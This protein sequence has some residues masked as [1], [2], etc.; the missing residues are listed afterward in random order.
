VL[1][2][3][4]ADAPSAPRPG[5]SGPRATPR[6]LDSAWNHPRVSSAHPHGVLRNGF[7]LVDDRGTVI[8]VFHGSAWSERGTI[9]AG[10]STWEF[11]RH[12]GG[13]LSLSGP[14]GEVASARRAGPF[15][16]T[17][18]LSYDGRS[19]SL[20][21]RGFWT[22]CYELRD[23]AGGVVGEVAQDSAF[24]RGLDVR[25]PEHVPAQTQA[26]VAAVVLTLMNRSRRAGASAGT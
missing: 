12:G 24:G 18:D 10:S 19:G 14:D 25:L 6:Q 5:T 7:D 15:S 16:S 4:T 8:A 3:P 23:P 20:V 1:Q 26:F 21:R 13:C 9:S 11:G 2:P 22:S 17:W